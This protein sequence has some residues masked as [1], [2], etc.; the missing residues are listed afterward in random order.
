MHRCSRNYK[1]GSIVNYQWIGSHYTE[2][3]LHRQKLTIRQL[4]LEVI[5]K[6]SIEV[7]ISQCRRAKQYA[8]N[9]IEGALIEHYV[10]L[11][12]YGEE[13]RRSN[14]GSTVSMDV[15]TMLD[16]TN[17]FSKK[18]IG[19]DGCFLKGYVT[20]ELLC[21]VGKD[22][23]DQIYLIAWA[24]VCVENKENR[25]WFLSLLSDDLNLGMGKG[26]TLISD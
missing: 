5:K 26:F 11:W 21:V 9:I 8:I 10:K 19:I 1:L 20:G 22:A 23:R 18:V 16:A 7:G 2:E 14:P 13:I 12:S 15:L 24:V 6:F 25:K 4:R 17:H 3:I